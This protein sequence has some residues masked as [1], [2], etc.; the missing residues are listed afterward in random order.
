MPNQLTP[1]Q[2]LNKAFLKIKPIRSDIEVFKECI[3]KLLDNASDKESEEHQKNLLIEFFKKTHFSDDYY[4]NTKD[5]TDLVIHSGKSAK[6]SVAVMMEVKR[7]TNSSEMLSEKNIN[8]KALQ[9][10]VFYYLKERISCKNLDIKNIIATNINEWFIFDA[11]IFEK[12]FAQDKKLVKA[13][14]QFLIEGKDTSFFYSE[15]AKP[16]IE[17]H[18]DELSYTYFNFKEYGKLAKKRIDKEDNKL[19]PLYKLLSKEHL[20][21][22]PF[23]NDSNSLNKNFYAELLHLI[24]LEETKVGTK[25][26]IERKKDGERNSGSLLEMAISLIKSR[27]RLY[28]LNHPQH[29][30]TTEGEQMVAVGLELVITWINRILFLKLLEAQLIKYNKGD[31]GY[32][33]LNTTKIKNFG[34]LDALFFQVL[35]VKNSERDEIIKKE[36]ER[37]P[38]LNSSLFEQTSLESATVTVANLSDNATLPILSN[39]VLKDELGRKKTGDLA[40]LN[41]LFNFLN[42]YDFTSDGGE[43][44]QEDNKTLINASVLGLIFEKIN[45]YK[46]GSYFTPSF[47]TM[48]MCKETIRK[49]IVD[50]FNKVKNKSCLDLV[51]VYNSIDDVDEMNDIING[52]KICDPAVGSG[53]FL[54]S[55][56]NEIIYI[57]SYLRILRDKEGKSLRDYT[58]EVVND[59]LIVTDGDG[60]LVEYY[61]KNKESQRIQETLFDEKRS[62]IENCLFGVDINANSV[63][64]CRL[65]LWIE[66]LKNSYYRDDSE[67]ET[68]PNIDINIKV[69]D[70]LISRFAIDADVKDALKQSKLSVKK[71]KTVVAEYKNASDKQEK[72]R[73]EKLISEI[74][75]SFRTEIL[76][77]DKKFIR[78][79]NIKD[80][81]QTLGAQ[82]LLFESESRANSAEVKIIKLNEERTIL[83]NQIEEIRANKLYENAFEWRFEMPEVLNDE[84]D[85][86]GFDVVIGNPPYIDSEMMVNS[87][88]MAEREYISDVYMY[89]K[90]NWDIYIAFFERGIRLLKKDSYLSFITPDTWL[91]KTYGMELRK[92]LLPNFEKIVKLGREVFESADL[93]CIVTLIKTANLEFLEAGELKGDVYQPINTITKQSATSPYNLDFIF[94]QKIFYLN[95]LEALSGTLKN[96]AI[97][98]SACSTSDCYLLKDFI[99]ESNSTMNQNDYFRLVNSGTLDKYF[100]KWGDKEMTYLKSKFKMPLVKRTDFSTNFKNSYYA[101]SVKPKIIIKGLRKLDA[102][103]DL[104]GSY[105]AGKSTLVITSQDMDSLKLILGVVNSFLGIAYIQEKYSAS[106]YNGGIT[107]TKDMFNKFPLPL[108]PSIYKTKIIQCV[109]E[110]LTSTDVVAIADLQKQI[111]IYVSHLYDF[112]YI[113]LE[114]FLEGSVPFSEAELQK[115]TQH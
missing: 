55:A 63:K 76:S 9:E 6:D 95:R 16:F 114:N 45:G 100:D 92:S 107:F 101:K 41:Y 37:V 99:V 32:S 51:D 3:L 104:S 35:A 74:K 31:V 54:V 61:P 53:H 30:G 94:S 83:E 59:E 85:Y 46:D 98:E 26:L 56:L 96:V 68:L 12:C 113:D 23:L 86:V 8:T 108:N 64:I 43:E 112:T 27:G 80:E 20:L 18:K 77:N 67:L 25:K 15:I 73:L 52:I 87:G 34:E 50:R 91:S 4:V 14:E 81:I 93:P 79:R 72:R 44:I 65:R 58:I 22:K 11:N 38:Y 10:L 60:Q 48:Y 49:V 13:F 7:T 115:L 66:L 84:G 88:L 36:F 29:F 69:G 70:S 97:C 19:I 103:L 78:L 39:T 102:S 75:S 82:S 47:V 28:D 106:T 24:G 109:D 33:F 90:G 5:R 62:I 110:I 21:K 105:I 42:A 1:R 71:Y 57:K 2:A 89:A 111:D 40:T 17:K